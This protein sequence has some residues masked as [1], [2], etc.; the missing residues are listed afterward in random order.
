M[1][2][3]KSVS[4]SYPKRP[5]PVFNNS[6]FTSKIKSGDCIAIV[7]ANGSGKTT[8]LKLIS[9]L[10]TPYNGTAHI[11]K[12]LKFSYLTQLQHYDRIY[13]LTVFD[14]VNMA[15]P[16]PKLSWTKPTNKQKELTEKALE[17]VSLIDK[18][19][20]HIS[21]LSG[22]EFQRMLFAR[23]LA[24]DSNI[25]LLD[26]PFT[27]IDETTIETLLGLMSKTTKQLNK[28][29]LCICHDLNFAQ[30]YFTHILHIKK[31]QPIL[32]TQSDWRL[33][34]KKNGGRYAL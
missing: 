34:L 18:K 8:F 16:I 20:G 13:P 17:T 32:Y 3:F 2:T 9:G 6:T 25:I 15:H 1:I 12:G 19:N 33:F 22:G 21:N 28:T 23:T 5:Q 14:V 24:E 26:E 10:L 7:G 11:D 27:S 31:Q 29:I 30:E 4:F